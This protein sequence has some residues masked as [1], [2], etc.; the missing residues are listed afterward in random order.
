MDHSG[1]YDNSVTHQSS[2]PRFS[3]SYGSRYSKKCLDLILPDFTKSSTLLFPQFV[4]VFPGYI[5]TGGHSHIVGVTLHHAVHNINFWFVSAK[6]LIIVYTPQEEIG[7]LL[8]SQRIL[9][10][11]I[12]ILYASFSII[13]CIAVLHF[14]INTGCQFVWHW[15]VSFPYG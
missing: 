11:F 14:P 12:C 6:V 1:N 5:V 13:R 9:G 10:Y 3:T 8:L 7:C 2:V 15:A 4:L